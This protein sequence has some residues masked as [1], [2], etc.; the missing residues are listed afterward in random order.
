MT[1]PISTAKEEQPNS[2][3]PR[4]RT[5]SRSVAPFEV[6]AGSLVQLIRSLGSWRLGESTLWGTFGVKDLDDDDNDDEGDRFEFI[7]PPIRS[8]T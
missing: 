2:S 3:S 7:G 8:P 4:T 6:R 5:E 1:Y